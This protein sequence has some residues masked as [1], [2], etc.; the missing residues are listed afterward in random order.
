MERFE[1]EQAHPISLE[2]IEELTQRQ[3]SN[4][5]IERLVYVETRQKGTQERKIFPA[6][7][8]EVM[9]GK[10][11][12]VIVMYVAQYMMRQ[13]ITACV[14]VPVKDIGATFRI[15]NLPPSDSLMER[16]P[17]ADKSEVQ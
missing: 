16:M 5:C 1:R 7:P 10:D 14:T 9:E 15:W 6:W 2:E 17:L 13:Y 8:F 11:G 12:K 4:P 3:V